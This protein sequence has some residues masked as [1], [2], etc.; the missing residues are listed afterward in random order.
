MALEKILIIMLLSVS[1]WS[2]LAL[3]LDR[4]GDLRANR[5]FAVLLGV[6]CISQIF[7]YSLLVASPAVSIFAQLSLASI[8]LKGPLILQLVQ[9]LI[10][11]GAGFKSIAW[12]F[13]GFPLAL[14]INFLVPQSQLLW[15]LLGS[16][17]SLGVLL[18]SA[19][20]LWQH[21]N[22]L[23]GICAEYQNTAS[24]WLLFVVLGM[25]VLLLADVV[26]FGSALYL[27][28][29]PYPAAKL[30]T[31]AASLYLVC[32]AFFTIYRPQVF[33][34]SRPA[35]R[36]LFATATQEAAAIDASV[37]AEVEAGGSRNLELD[38]SIA[39]ALRQELE[40]LM[41]VD[42]LYRQYE[43]SLASLAKA[44]GISV[45]QASELLN[46]H[47]HTNFYAYVNTYRLKYAAELLS[48]PTC[49]LRVLDI[50]FE[51][52]FNNKNSF[53]REFRSAYGATPTEY[54]NQRLLPAIS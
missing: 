42:C 27:Q 4:R 23:Q 9:L 52:G 16:C 53:Y 35:E 18:W 54:R 11:K 3:L 17:L 40:R 44:L 34:H 19:V 21:R 29:F 5:Y 41:A 14:A 46:V 36:E 2:A 37:K 7:I 39:S 12:H 15:H 43:L 50:A 30:L 24:Y 10:G 20:L 8:W 48:N 45:H 32:L 28:S 31:F 6:F 38:C 1:G 33:F 13:S 25:L 22:R 49:Q 51:S 47:M 26:L